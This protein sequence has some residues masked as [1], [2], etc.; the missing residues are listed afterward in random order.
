MNTKQYQPM[1]T[2]NTNQGGGGYDTDTR[3]VVVSTWYATLVFYGCIDTSSI[4]ELVNA[5]IKYGISPL[6]VGP[7]FALN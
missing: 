3:K 6:E 4:I 7:E 1:I 5:I 2:D